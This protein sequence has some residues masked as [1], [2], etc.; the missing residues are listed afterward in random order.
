MPN[1]KKKKKLLIV[2]ALYLYACALVNV[3]RTQYFNYVLEVR[4]TLTRSETSIAQLTVISDKW[5]NPISTVFLCLFLHRMSA[6][7]ANFFF[8]SLLTKKKGSN[9]RYELFLFCYCELVSMSNSNEV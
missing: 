5:Q 1:V 9:H 2:G 7:T 8:L 3:Y 4:G 6:G